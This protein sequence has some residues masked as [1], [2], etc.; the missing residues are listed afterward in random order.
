MSGGGSPTP[1]LSCCI[2]LLVQLSSS[3]KPDSLSDFSTDFLWK[4]TFWHRNQWHFTF[5]LYFYSTL[6]Y[7]KQYLV[8]SDILHLCF[9]FLSLYNSTDYLLRSYSSAVIFIYVLRIIIGGGEPFFT[10]SFTAVFF[11]YVVHY[12][13]TKLQ[14]VGISSTILYFGY[15]M[16]MVLIFFIFTGTVRFFF[17]CFWFITKIYSTVK[18]D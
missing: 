11:M 9:P 8:S 6:F 13:F 14:I 18:V 10:S 17:S 1:L 12:F 3:H 16:I 4:A 15:V 7:S 2:Y 5:W